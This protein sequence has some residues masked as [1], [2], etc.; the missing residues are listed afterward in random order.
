MKKN[1]DKLKKVDIIHII[2]D[3]IWILVAVFIGI[4]SNNISKNIAKFNNKQL[5]K[6]Y[7]STFYNTIFNTE[8][9]YNIRRNIDKD[10]HIPNDAKK[11]SFIDNFEWL[12][13]KYCD[14]MIY[15]KDIKTYNYIFEKTCNNQEIIN[16]FWWWKNAFSKICLDLW[17]TE[18][19]WKFFNQNS[20]CKILK[21]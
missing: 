1:N 12:W 18:W 13:E 4:Q 17:Y 2:I 14:E 7:C 15:L 6:E 10:G 16:I 3:I 20:N 21:N 9:F 11:T 19:M 8:E 5:S